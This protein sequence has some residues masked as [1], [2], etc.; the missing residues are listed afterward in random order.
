MD[1][2]AAAGG[3]KLVDGVMETTAVGAALDDTAATL[4]YE[5]C[6]SLTQESASWTKNTVRRIA[7]CR[8]GE[9]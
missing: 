5:N 9:E 4:Q 8:L 7:E 3:V 1:R 6:C 2:E